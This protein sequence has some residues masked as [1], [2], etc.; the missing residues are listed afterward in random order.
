MLLLLHLRIVIHIYVNFYQ[1]CAIWQRLEFC[2]VSI[3]FIFYWQP[4]G[5]HIFG[6][7]FLRY[8]NFGT[9][10]KRTVRCAVVFCI[11]LKA[12]RRCSTLHNVG[13][14]D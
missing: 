5:D 10:L 14:I 6:I 9:Q 2:I 4:K 3:N 8:I 7:T 13:K 12:K 11:M 1:A